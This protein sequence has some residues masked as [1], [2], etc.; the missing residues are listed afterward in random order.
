MSDISIAKYRYEVGEHVLELEKDC[1]GR[2]SKYICPV[3]SYFKR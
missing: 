1:V 3:T 2:F